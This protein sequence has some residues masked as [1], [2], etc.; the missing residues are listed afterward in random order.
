[1]DVQCWGPRKASIDEVFGGLQQKAGNE[2]FVCL[3]PRQASIDVLSLGP[4]KAGIRVFVW[5][6]GRPTSMCLSGAS[7]GRGDLVSVFGSRC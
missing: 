3:G 2:V 5:G 6:R 4:Q 1:M 7:A